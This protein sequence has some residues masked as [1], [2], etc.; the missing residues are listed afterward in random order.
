MTFKSIR[1]PNGQSVQVRGLPK[2]AL[3][4]DVYLADTSEVLYTT[5]DH[6]A[7]DN[8]SRDELKQMY[9]QNLHSVAK[10]RKENLIRAKAKVINIMDFDRQESA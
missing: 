3:N 2:I 5:R 9:T 4:G 7:F 10:W 8:L 6:G 1:M